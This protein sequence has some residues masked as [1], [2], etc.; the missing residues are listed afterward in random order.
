LFK[1]G[2][3]WLLEIFSLPA[4]LANSISLRAV[5]KE[6]GCSIGIDLAAFLTSVV[7]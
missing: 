6:L 2:L 3:V 4:G 7:G 5:I 1:K